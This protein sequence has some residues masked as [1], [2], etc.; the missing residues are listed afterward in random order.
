V[1]TST[2]K[3]ATNTANIEA[4]IKYNSIQ[5]GH[6]AAINSKME[7]LVKGMFA[8]GGMVVVTLLAVLGNLLIK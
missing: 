1:P 3:V 6:I 2:E 7:S 8:I 5:N 4:I